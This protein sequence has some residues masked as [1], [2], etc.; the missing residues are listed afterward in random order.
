MHA[1]GP[2]DVGGDAGA[3]AGGASGGGASGSGANG[4]SANGGGPNGPG[5]AIGENEIDNADVNCDHLGTCYDGMEESAS[6][7]HKCVDE[8]LYLSHQSQSTA[9]TRES[10]ST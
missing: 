9:R 10:S 3:N 5:G 4:G 2:A 7:V 1:G 8:R 6:Y